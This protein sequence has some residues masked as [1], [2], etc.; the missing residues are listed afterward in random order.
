MNAFHGITRLC[1]LVLFTWTLQLVVTVKAASKGGRAHSKHRCAGMFKWY[2]NDLK[3]PAVCIARKGAKYS[4]N[5]NSCTFAD[6]PLTHE[7]FYFSACLVTFDPKNNPPDL[8][9]V[10]ATEMYDETFGAETDHLITIAGKPKSEQYGSRVSAACRSQK[11]W[12]DHRPVCKECEVLKPPTT[13]Y[14]PP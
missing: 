13:P 11:G 12:N 3:K 7:S 1:L 4:C 14:S 8:I 10:Y 6:Q 2:P 5:P 9:R